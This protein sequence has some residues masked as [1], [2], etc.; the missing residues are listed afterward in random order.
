MSDTQQEN[1]E[2]INVPE[3]VPGVSHYTQRYLT[4][5]RLFSFA[6][7][8]QSVL[9]TKA[10]S[11]LEVGCGIGYV[12]NNLRAIGIEVKTLDLQPELQPDVLGSVTDIPLPDD[13][14]D[15]VVCCQVLEH[16]PFEEFAKA[17]QQLRP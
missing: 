3:Q 4:G 11:V 6:H 16:L 14:V 10:K 13:S 8:I 1:S 15:M 5:G 9:D 17:L 12:T 7:Q 2:K